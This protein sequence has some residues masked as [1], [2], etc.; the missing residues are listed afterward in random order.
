MVILLLL[1]VIALK[2]IFRPQ[3]AMAD[4]KYGSIQFS[5]IGG[6]PAFFDISSSDVWLHD[7]N[8]YFRQYHKVNPFGK[9]LGR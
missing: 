3:V 9:N 6:E 8:G 4:G 7:K 5:Y 2:P 1:S